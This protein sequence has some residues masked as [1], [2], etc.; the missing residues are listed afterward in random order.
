MTMHGRAK[1]LILRKYDDTGADTFEKHWAQIEYTAYWCVHLLL[2]QSGI[3][4]VIPEG[5]DDVT[6]VKSDCFELHQVKCR[7]ESQAPWTTADILPILC[8]QYHRR[9][10][11]EKQCEFHFV[12]DHVADAKTQFRPGNS[13][14]QL[15]RLKHLLDIKHQGD[16]FTAEEAKEL[17]ELEAVILPRI[18]ELMAK[19]GETVNQSDAQALLHDTWIDT[20]SLYIRNRPIYSELSAAFVEAFPGQPA[21]NVP[22]LEEIYCRLLLHIVGKIIIGRTLEART[23]ARED[24]LTCRVEAITPEANLP[25]LNKLQ[26]HTTAEKKALY[27]GFDTTEF[28]IIS[29]QMRRMQEK[30][31]RLE[32]LGFYENIEDLSLALLT[33]QSY[34]RRE[35]SKSHSELT[36]GPKILHTMQSH[37]QDV[38]NKY[39][40]TLIEVDLPFCHGLL[41]SSTNDC[42]LWW[43][44]LDDIEVVK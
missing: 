6:L 39:V 31:R 8:S 7:D 19:E 27:G 18:I 33:L 13:Y 12:S 40:P 17:K 29:L 25:D 2:P 20:K 5:I 15:F 37:L 10:A 44:R 3:I 38:I 23:I 35:I 28:P 41:W 30:R 36:I 4:G 21:C 16:S 9:T 32:T 26:G 42:H 11:F 43:H 1:E 34:H 24:V 14:G 22:Q